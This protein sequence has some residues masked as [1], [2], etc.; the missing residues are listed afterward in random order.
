MSMKKL[1][2]ASHNK[3]KAQEIANLLNS[4][5]EISTL[6]EIGLTEEIAETA[7]TLEG[8]ALIKARYVYEKTRC[9]CFADDT[10]LIVDAIG[11]APGVYSA[12]FAGEDG[13][14]ERNMAKLLAMMDGKDNRAARFK[15]VVVYISDGKEYVFDGIVEGEITTE[16]HGNEG[17]GYDPVFA[18]VEAGGKTFAEMTLDEKNLISHRAR[19]VKK[20]VE[21][22]KGRN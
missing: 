20:F 13:N 16:K 6:D 8:N 12:R 3:H 4:E 19:A 17:F 15:T 22:L 2:F 7:E 14:A 10:G 1:V 21:F 9:D 5:Y 11:G 18:P